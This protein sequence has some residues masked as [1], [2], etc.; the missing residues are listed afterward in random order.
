MYNFVQDKEIT[1]VK[2]CRFRFQNV[3]EVNSKS[4]RNVGASKNL[5][6]PNGN[7]R[8]INSPQGV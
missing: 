3:R 8:H 4:S 2:R 6:S 1:G 5:N 7:S